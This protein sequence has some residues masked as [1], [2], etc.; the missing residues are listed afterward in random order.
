MISPAE[1]SAQAVEMLA[2]GKSIVVNVDSLSDL[3]VAGTVRIRRVSAKRLRDRA[4]RMLLSATAP[5]SIFF[6]EMFSSQIFLF[7]MPA[8]CRDPSVS[9]SWF[10]TQTSYVMR[11]QHL[12]D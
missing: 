1:L 6:M 5:E 4:K 8:E 11:G 10:L 2:P 3:T 9:R 12:P 7:H